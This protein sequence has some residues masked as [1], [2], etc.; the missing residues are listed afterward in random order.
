MKYLIFSIIFSGLF[1]IANSNPIDR[2]KIWV[3]V[4]SQSVVYVRGYK[5][6]HLPG[7][8]DSLLYATLSQYFKDYHKIPY[9]KIVSLYPEYVPEMGLRG[10]INDAIYHTL[11][12]I[13]TTYLY[14]DNSKKHISLTDIPSSLLGQFLPGL[15]KHPATL[16]IEMPN[17]Y[18]SKNL[19][20]TIVID[21]IS[22]FG[23]DHSC[24][25]LL[26]QE[27]ASQ[28]IL[29]INIRGQFIFLLG[30][31]PLATPTKNKN[32]IYMRNDTLWVSKKPISLHEL[33]NP[34][35][36]IWGFNP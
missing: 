20:H 19:S 18:S 11:E 36:K 10:D 4:D 24:Y 22:N 29:L 13:N 16:V 9:I 6:V 2:S 34:Y 30:Y 35:T 28:F 12:K 33:T 25:A 21:S 1:S 14:D 3:L 5:A 26:V 8:I 31:Y 7:D 15:N 23:I 17:A 27:Q 32:D